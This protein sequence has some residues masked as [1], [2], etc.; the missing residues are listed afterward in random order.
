MVKFKPE[1]KTVAVSTAL[2]LGCIAVL[3]AMSGCDKQSSEP[4]QVN[5]HNS[6]ND[7]H[8]VFQF[9]VYEDSGN[10]LADIAY[11]E[12]KISYSTEDG[13][14]WSNAMD[15]GAVYDYE[16]SFSAGD[17]INLTIEATLTGKPDNE[18][19]CQ[20][21]EDGVNLEKSV[22]TI[23]KNETTTTTTCNYS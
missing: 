18:I 6:N 5:D 19:E 21:V 9:R 22:G 4:N 3:I 2:I 14:Q 11:V 1:L 17:R 16:T 7:H 10:K 8:I 12:L 20:V 15:V 13:G 23:K